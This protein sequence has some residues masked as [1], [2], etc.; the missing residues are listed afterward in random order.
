MSFIERAVLKAPRGFASRLRVFLYRCLG[1]KAGKRN[2]LERVRCRR[3]S[4]IQLG[5]FNSFTEGCW[6]WPEDS[7]FEGRRIRIGSYNYFNRDVTIDACG[8]VEIGDENMFGPGVYLADSNH[9]YQPDIPP[10]RLAMDIGHIKIGNG[11]WI[12]AKAIILKNVEL[13]D[14]CVVGAGSVVTK[15]FPAGSVVAGVP[16]RLMRQR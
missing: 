15:T 14:F 1:L 6:L 7:A 4:Q 13:G 9:R 16:A 11:C 12:G 10:H 2:R 3:L 8:S 5:D